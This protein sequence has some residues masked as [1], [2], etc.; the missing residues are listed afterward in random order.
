MGAVVKGGWWFF[1]ENVLIYRLR[2]ANKTSRLNVKN[3]ASTIE[4]LTHFISSDLCSGRTDYGPCLRCL[5]SQMNASSDDPR[6]NR[7]AQ[8]KISHIDLNFQPSCSRWLWMRRQASCATLQ[9]IQRTLLNAR[10]KDIVRL[11]PLSVIRQINHTTIGDKTD[12][13]HNDQDEKAIHE[14]H[15]GCHRNWVGWSPH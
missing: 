7:L 6:V 4:W 14:I 8:R 15:S 3:A 9:I 11:I 12:Q 10:M 2:Q 13:S 5:K 1:G